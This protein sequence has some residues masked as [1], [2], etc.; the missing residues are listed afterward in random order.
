MSD[1][2]DNISPNESYEQEFSASKT[3]TVSIPIQYDYSTSFASFSSILKDQLPSTTSVVS[4]WAPSSFG[5]IT[6]IDQY[7]INSRKSSSLNWLGMASSSSIYSPDPVVQA[8]VD[9]ETFIRQL[10]NDSSLGLFHMSEHIRKRVPQIVDE[11][12]GLIGLTKE[13]EITIE[14]MKDSCE[15]VESMPK[16]PC[17]NN[18][19]EM[20]KSTLA[21]VEAVKI[22]EKK[23]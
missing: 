15:T 23:T 3:N 9:L 19:N 8:C 4:N 5:S 21:I 12:K 13:V 20:L 1:I 10:Y 17:F 16:I 2:N 7:F 22:K 14:D 11:K 6:T 18:I